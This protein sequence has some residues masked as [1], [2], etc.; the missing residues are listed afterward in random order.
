[1]ATCFFAVGFL[2]ATSQSF[3]FTDNQLAIMQHVFTDYP[4][5]DRSPFIREMWEKEFYKPTWSLIGKV[6]THVR[7]FS[8]GFNSTLQFAVAAI[9]ETGLTQPD[10]WLN[11]YNMVLVRD[12]NGSITLRQHRP[13]TSIPEPRQLTDVELLFRVLKRGLPVKNPVDLLD[14]LV[15][16]QKHYM[17]VTD[18][19][20]PSGLADI[21][22]DNAIND[23][24]FDAF[25]YFVELAPAHNFFERGVAVTDGSVI[26][27]IRIDD[28][29]LSTTDHTIGGFE[30]DNSTAHLTVPNNGALN[31]N[32]MTDAS[33]VLDM[34]LPPH[35][36]GISGQI[37]QNAHQIGQFT[38]L[39]YI[40]LANKIL[41]PPIQSQM[42][43]ILTQSTRISSINSPVGT[44]SETCKPL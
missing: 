30:F 1:M 43:Q 33:Q 4:Q 23:V 5:A 17:T 6:W 11:T 36:D 22:F 34:G 7:D 44:S 8:G 37:T 15:K 40:H 10:L 16:S 19:N 24:P 3:L 26:G 14:K 20:A 2:I 25:S 42:T 18:Q 29:L 38:L 39:F 12:N 9:E 13:P 21:D 27:S 32:T 31:T 28:A 41:Q 35:W